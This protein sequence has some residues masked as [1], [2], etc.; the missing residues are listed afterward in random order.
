MERGLTQG[1]ERSGLIARGFRRAASYSWEKTTLDTIAVYEEA[2][3]RGV[4]RGRPVA[5]PG[6]DALSRAIARTVAYGAIFDYPMKLGEIHRSLSEWEAT[7][8]QI[9]TVLASHPWLKARIERR[10]AYYFIRGRGRSVPRRWNR[11]RLTHALRRRQA[12][13]S[14]ARALLQLP[15]R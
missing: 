15:G 4:V 8:A 12:G 5:A 9:E 14:Q 10:G 11:E 1:E 13:R 2:A 6:A 7:P 3:E